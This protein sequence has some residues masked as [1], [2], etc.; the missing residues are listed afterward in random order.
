MKNNHKLIGEIGNAFHLS[1]CYA[2]SEK[3]RNV[4]LQGRILDWEETP[5]DFLERVI[6]AIFSVENEFGTP[7]ERIHL[8]AEE[9]AEYMAR[10]CITLGSPT[11]TNAGRYSYALSSCAMLPVDLS[12][13]NETTKESIRSHYTQNMGGGFEFNRY[14]DPV[15]KLAWV[16]EFAAQESA[17]GN[18]ERYIG[19]MGLLHV[20]HPAIRAFIEA[21][22][23]REMKHFNISIDVTEE[24]M[25]RAENDA[26]ITLG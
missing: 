22:R 23:Q 18:Y 3:A 15:A 14:D 8:M 12:V 10:G 2:P 19:N 21:K 26:F 16:N 6:T 17:T 1:C 5:Q 24:F 20:S 25:R 7:Q 9:F 4:L 11:L 13:L